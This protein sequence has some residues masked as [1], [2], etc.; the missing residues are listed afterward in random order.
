MVIS[1]KNSKSFIVVDRYKKL[2]KEPF[3]VETK[4]KKIINMNNN[5][6]NLNKIIN[7]KKKRL[8]YIAKAHT[9]QPPS[10]TVWA[11]DKL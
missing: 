10:F 6:Q 5:K 7:Y 9:G 8:T 2:T 1:S 11:F 4:D 3:K